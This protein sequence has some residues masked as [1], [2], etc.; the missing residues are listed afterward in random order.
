MYYNNTKL[1]LSFFWVLLGTVL[2]ILGLA[3]RIDPSFFG[4]LGGSLAAVGIL[5]ITKNIKYRT[6]SEYREKLNT[7]MND[8][9][10]RYIRMKSWSWAGYIV[11]LVEAV[12]MFVALILGQH[13]VQLVLA[14]SV[15]LILL[16]YWLAYMILSKKY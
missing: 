10:N 9:R 14:N 13:T 4:C 1:A 5:Q 11:T 7:E 2:I 6:N 12:G 3:K 8:E 16:T 15:C